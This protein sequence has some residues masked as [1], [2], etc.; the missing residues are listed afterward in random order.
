MTLDGVLSVLAGRRGVDLRDYRVESLARGLEGRLAALSLGGLDEYGRR[1]EE[2]PTEMDQLL[3]ALLVPFTGFF[4]DVEVFEA[5]RLAVIPRLAALLDPSLPLRAWAAGVAT[6]E[7]A[8]S[9]AMLLADGCA[10][11]PPWRFEVIGTDLDAQALAAAEQ[12][13]YPEESLATIPSPFARR[14]VEQGAISPALRPAVRFA[15]HDLVG[16]VL[17]PR[18]AIVASFSLVL[19][20]NVLIYFDR[21]LQLKALDRLAA[22]IEPGGALV[23]GDAE[24]LPAAL[25]DRFV[26][27]PGVAARLRVYQRRA[28]QA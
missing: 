18:E 26:P 7:E 15:T 20:R 6:G 4:R 27:F 17:A 19:A 2:D 28:G 23:L 1:L 25:A 12:G 24:T 13:R 11:G 9:L 10:S 22:V 3:R 14:F 16:R 21:R 5:L 8:W